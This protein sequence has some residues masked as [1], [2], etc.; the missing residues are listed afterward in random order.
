METFLISIEISGAD[1]ERF[2][3]VDA[4]VDARSTYSA[5]PASLLRSLGV[6]PFAKRQS[7]NPDDGSRICRDLG[8]MSVRMNGEVL[9]TPVVFADESSHPILGAVT[10]AAFCLEA[11][12]ANQRLIEATAFLPSLLLIDD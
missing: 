12:Y 3:T 2:E 9:T 1:R 6:S 7:F 11:D 10:L 5:M 8:Q 4:L